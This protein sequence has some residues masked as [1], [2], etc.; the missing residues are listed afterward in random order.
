MYSAHLRDMYNFDPLA[1]ERFLKE[2]R[3]LA[4]QGQNVAQAMKSKPLAQGQQIAGDDARIAGSGKEEDNGG[5]NIN[6]EGANPE[7][8]SQDEAR[9]NNGI[10]GGRREGARPRR[11][12]QSQG[13][14]RYGTTLHSRA[15][16]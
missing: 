12:N 4:A 9:T 8:D 14:T 11:G 5:A 3:L 6:S 1:M 7:N 15:S 13:P 2:M 16:G 10:A